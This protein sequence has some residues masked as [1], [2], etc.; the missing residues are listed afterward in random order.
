MVR[1]TFHSGDTERYSPPPLSPIPIPNIGDNTSRPLYV[2]QYPQTGTQITDPSPGELQ[3][4]V[5][6]IKLVPNPQ[7]SCE[8]QTELTLQDLEKLEKK[9]HRKRKCPEVKEVATSTSDL[10]HYKQQCMDASTSTIINCVNKTTSRNTALEFHETPTLSQAETFLEC[11]HSHA[12]C[13]D[14]WALQQHSKCHT[15]NKLKYGRVCSN[16][17]KDYWKFF[18]VIQQ[19][20]YSLVQEQLHLINSKLQDLNALHPKRKPRTR[21]GRF[22]T[23]PEEPPEDNPPGTSAESTGVNPDGP[24]P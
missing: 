15:C 23:I 4:P 24:S 7:K 8:I 2:Q 3:T 16:C 12:P 14:Q 20:Q 5:S 18:A 13:Y 11:V 17:N 9:K 6:V 10:P 21:H 1:P 19:H 22:A